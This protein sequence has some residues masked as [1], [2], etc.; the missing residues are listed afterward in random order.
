M[1]KALI[2][3][4]LVIITAVFVFMGFVP[5]FMGANESLYMFGYT[6]AGQSGIAAWEPWGRW[7]IGLA[8]LLAVVML[9]VPGRRYLGGALT[10][11]LM[12]GAVGS[13]LLWIGINTQFPVK[14][15]TPP[16][17]DATVTQGDNG[18]LFSVAV[19]VLVCG[20]IT[21]LRGRPNQM[22]FKS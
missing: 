12:A 4:P 3:I 17:S 8:E 21:F 18:F 5:K 14:G 13:H 16:F 6:L 11:V 9:W 15:Q 22:I 10:A 1:Q 7:A 2:Y 20:V 19:V